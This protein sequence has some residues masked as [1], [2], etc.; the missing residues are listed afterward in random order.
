MPARERLDPGTGLATA[1]R[2]GLRAAPGPEPVVPCRLSRSPPPVQF[3][4]AASLARGRWRRCRS[5]PAV[6]RLS[7]GTGS[8]GAS[9]A[10]VRSSKPGS[11]LTES[12][13]APVPADGAL[14]IWP[15]IE[16]GG[17]HPQ[18]ET[19]PPAHGGR[20]ATCVCRGPAGAACRLQRIRTSCVSPVLLSLIRTSRPARI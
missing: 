8:D 13:R 10:A 7:R 2:S 14:Y 4:P 17:L 3:L 16:N 6:A 15:A 20:V 18:Q 1:P 19:G 5:R 12:R 11:R 9:R